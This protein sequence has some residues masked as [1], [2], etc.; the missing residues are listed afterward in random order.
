MSQSSTHMLCST[1]VS[2][3]IRHGNLKTSVFNFCGSMLPGFADFNAKNNKKNLHDCNEY[4]NNDELR[5]TLKFSQLSRYANKQATTKL[6]R[7]TQSVAWLH[8]VHLLCTR[9]S[10]NGAYRDHYTNNL[11]KLSYGKNK[12]TKVSPEQQEKMT[13]EVM[14]SL[15]S[16]T[17]GKDYAQEHSSFFEEVENSDLE[18][19]TENVA[20]TTSSMEDELTNEVQ[21][22][23]NPQ[24]RIS[25]KQRKASLEEYQQTFLQVPRIDDRKPVFVSSDVR[26]RLDRVVRI[27]GGRRMSVSGIIENIVRHHLSLYEKDFEAWR[28]L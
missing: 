9:Q 23:P 3:K 13:Q 28:K 10:V 11:N 19:V 22:P 21:S 1:F 14:A 5:N 17:Y 15:Q 4:M 18:V 8:S 27:L 6:P 24:K 2:A 16:S 25:G 26:D 12:E 7:Y 20:A